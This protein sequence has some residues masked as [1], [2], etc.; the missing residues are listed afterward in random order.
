MDSTDAEFDWILCSRRE[1]SKIRNDNQALGAQ[2]R[3]YHD[4]PEYH[5]QHPRLENQLEL[6]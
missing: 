6:F 4:D 1:D 3:K 2:E 5:N